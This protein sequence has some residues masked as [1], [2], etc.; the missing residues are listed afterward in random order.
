M[1]IIEKFTKNEIEEALSLTGIKNLI[2]SDVR[3]LSGGEFQR[4]LMARA[5]AKNLIFCIR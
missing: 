4:L 5:V 3:N 2:F 1:N